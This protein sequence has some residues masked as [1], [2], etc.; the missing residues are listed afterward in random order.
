MI[1]TNSE[2]EPGH[3]WEM[4]SGRGVGPLPFSW[5]KWMSMSS[6]GAVKCENRLS[7]S[8]WVRQSNS[9]SQ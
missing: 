9:A 5:T 7:L 3:P 4:S 6:T 2:T 1:S 8:S